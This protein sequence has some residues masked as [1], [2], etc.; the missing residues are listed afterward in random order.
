MRPLEIVGK[1]KREL[2]DDCTARHR[3]VVGGRGKGASWSIA[4]IL[5]HE[6][7]QK[8]L[9]VACIREVQDSIKL[10]VK[11]LLEDTIILMGWQRFY[12]STLSEIRGANGTLFTFH[13][14]HDHSADT[15]KSLE[16]ADR[17]WVAEA[18][19]IARRSIDVLRPTIR[20]DD[21]VV[22][23]DV[24]PRYDTD[25]VYIDYIAHPE[26]NEDAKVCFVSWRDNPWF[27]KAL[28]AEMEADFKRDPE[29]AA[30]IWEG[31]IITSGNLFVFTSDRV[32][33][34]MYRDKAD[35]DYEGPEEV[36]ADIAHMGGDEIVFYKRR[37]LVTVDEYITRLQD[38]ETT[39]RD[40][41]GFTGNPRNRIK[42][43]NGNVGAVVAEN[44]IK[45]GYHNVHRINF[46]GRPV[47]IEHYG[48]CATE[49]WFNLRDMI[50]MPGCK[51]PDDEELRAQLV[52]RRYA[53]SSKRGFD[54]QVI[55]SKESF[56]GHM[57]AK[58][59][60]PDRADALS[61]CYYDPTAP[62][63]L[64]TEYKPAIMRLLTHA[65]LGGR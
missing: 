30:H 58:N 2:V 1:I 23:W 15:I 45:K 6:A 28:K 26:L 43:D 8:K 20:K 37:G 5:L 59:K 27:T 31:V 9:F 55:E 40:L 21:S 44:I 25:P 29:R 52:G 61:L 33:D 22:W 3:L 38:I 39:S 60:S 18:Q 13:G 51:I 12:S 14:L 50:N 48:D 65:Y 17:F 11:K 54:V 47:D 64:S 24:N 62:V 49:M 35:F 36:G 4:R 10:S 56:A 34:A 63:A 7:M 46:G 19:A 57:I 16:G 32:E 41:M 42:I 53:W